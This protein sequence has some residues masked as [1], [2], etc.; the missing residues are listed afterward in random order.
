MEF[1]TSTNQ[2]YKLNHIENFYDVFTDY[3]FGLNKYIPFENFNIIFSGGI[4]YECVRKSNYKFDQDNLYDIDLFLYG[5]TDKKISTYNKIIL[6]LTDAG[7]EYIVGF[8]K[9]VVYIFIKDI[10]RI[11]QLVFTDFEN[12]HQIIDSFDFVH[13][14]SYYDGNNVYTK[15][16]ALTH[17]TNS[18][19]DINYRPNIHRYIKYDLRGVKLDNILYQEYD[20]VFDN[21]QYYKHLNKS[22]QTFEQVQKL[23]EKKAD[24]NTDMK[25]IMSDYFNLTLFDNLVDIQSQVDLSGKFTQYTNDHT[26][27]DDDIKAAKGGDIFSF[28][29]QKYFYVKGKVLSS[30]LVDY[31]GKYK[32]SIELDNLRVINYLIG[33][34]DDIKLQL[35]NISKDKDAHNNHMSKKY[36]NPFINSLGYNLN[37]SSYIEQVGGLVIKIYDTTPL[38]SDTIYHFIFKP[39]IFNMFQINGF[40]IKIVEA[41]EKV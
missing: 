24:V 30:T 33:L 23:F 14:Q 18:T 16:N 17:I 29:N 27:E 37:N 5:D 41:I 35:D 26:I 28:E 2:N 21:L 10:P 8:V 15:Y 19:T 4:L 6:N 31:K 22:V 32:I 3:T 9:S 20:F 36:S 38:K 39:L 13:L 25:I 34:E 40:N 1:I 7:I 11:I 12:P